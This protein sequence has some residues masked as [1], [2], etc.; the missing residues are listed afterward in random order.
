MGGVGSGRKV[1]FNDPYHV[2]LRRRVRL[3]RERMRKLSK[4]YTPKG[5][6][7]LLSYSTTKEQLAKKMKS[8]EQENTQLK[9]RIKEL[10]SLVTPS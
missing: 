9:Q 4:H 6:L 1:E 10:E 2:E 7:D 3:Y 5:L 8:L